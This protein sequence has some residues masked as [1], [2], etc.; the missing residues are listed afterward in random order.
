MTHPKRGRGW[1]EN[2]A[3]ANGL[4]FYLQRGAAR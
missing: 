3:L 1:H 2:L 4:T